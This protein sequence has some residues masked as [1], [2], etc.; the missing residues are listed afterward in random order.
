MA[1][2]LNRLKA[3]VLAFFALAWVSVI[4]IFAVKPE[5]LDARLQV[6]AGNRR[7]ADVVFLAALTLFL[8]VLW[9]GVVRGWRWLFW[10][11]LVAFT[12]GILRVPAS[13]LELA[14]ALPPEG[15]AWYL[16]LQAAI[17]MVQFAIGLAMIVG[18]RRAG[19][20]AAGQRPPG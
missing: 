20:W 8:A 9:A 19:V 18:Y 2:R 6:N 12:A 17:G 4:A 13:A 11:V 7:L 5:I 3:A 1:V 16:M 14:N 10:L 15:P